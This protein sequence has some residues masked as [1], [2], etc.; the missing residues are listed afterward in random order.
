MLVIDWT[1][2][3]ECFEKHA[4]YHRSIYLKTVIYLNLN[5]L[6]IPAISLSQKAEFTSIWAYFTRHSN[7]SLTE[8]FGE[9]YVGNSGVFF[10]S[11]VIQ[12]AFITSGLQLVQLSSIVANYGSPWLTH[13]Q[14][15]VFSEQEPWFR[16]EASCFP[17]GFN[18][19]Y[20][21]VIF[22]TCIFFS[23]TIPL[24]SIAC[25]IYAMIRHAVDATNLLLVYRKE[26]DSQGTLIS[27][28]LNTLIVIVLVYQVCMAAFFAL[29]N[30]DRESICCVLMLILTA[31]F[32]VVY[33]VNVGEYWES[34]VQ[35]ET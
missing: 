13:F 15:K 30:K 23:A 16:T 8:A 32:F 19:A 21:I 25:M 34:Q 26:V 2:R 1:T 29:N 9:F 31:L 35:E 4:L 7:I 17:Y 14:R 28:A 10:I 22:A 20:I 27:D 3:F 33:N 6:I 18:Y 5:T 12:Q 11:L 24:L